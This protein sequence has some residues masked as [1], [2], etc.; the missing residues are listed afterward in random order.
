[1]TSQSGFQ[2]S[3][4]PLL[5][6]VALCEFMLGVCHLTL[7]MPLFPFLIPIVSG[8]FAL[9][10]AMHAVF[11]R[12]PN[13]VDFVLQCCSVCIAFILLVSSGMETFCAISYE[14]ESEEMLTNG[15]N[16]D[17]KFAFSESSERNFAAAVC[18]GLWYRSVG[19]QSSCN[20]LLRP[21]HE[22]LISKL[23]P[24]MH[25]SSMRFAISL[26]LTGLASLHFIV[27][28]AL[29]FYSAYETLLLVRSYH[30]QLIVAALMLPAA[31][32][33][34]EYCCTYFFIWP[35]VAV[36]LCATLQSILSWGF[37]CQGCWVRTLNV[38]GT[39]IGMALIAIASFG[40]F[41]TITSLLLL[42]SE[43]SSNRMNNQSR[44]RVTSDSFAFQRHCAWPPQQYRYCYRVIDFREPYKNWA[45]Q[46][47]ASETAAVQIF[48]NIWLC[49]CGFAQFFVSLKSTFSTE[50]LL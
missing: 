1:M 32:S 48:T 39:A 20:E 38:F 28:I 33:H 41:C 19:Y 6:I 16:D 24:T 9:I 26:S 45:R 14:D 5:A 15:L 42:I 7:C 31:V 47:I 17:V 21:M 30:V 50:V 25:L 36:F 37:D 13:R 43:T 27:C 8:V 49:L 35:G 22:S 23:G 3:L 40:I 34:H 29:A 2:W 4:Y 46:N 10:T 18:Y 12:Y 44:F 11:L